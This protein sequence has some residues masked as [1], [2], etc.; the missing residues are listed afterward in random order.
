[1]TGPRKQ[2]PQ[3]K[4]CC[5]CGVVVTL[6]S[7]FFNGLMVSLYIGLFRRVG[8]RKQHKSAGAVNICERC[9]EQTIATKGDCEAGRIL[10]EA[11]IQ[12]AAERYNIMKG[13]AA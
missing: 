12:R 5:A 13:V 3:P 7:D 10:A 4:T 2:K 9:L 1:M 11:I 6:E 8:R